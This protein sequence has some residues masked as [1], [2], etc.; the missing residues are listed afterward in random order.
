MNSFRSVPISGKHFIGKFPVHS[1]K[2]AD[3]FQLAVYVPVLLNGRVLGE[4]CVLG[5]AERRWW[6]QS[7]PPYHL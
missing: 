2:T 6:V 4:L 1:H 3:S 7:L 5:M